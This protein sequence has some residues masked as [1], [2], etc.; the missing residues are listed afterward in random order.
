M[1]KT[2]LQYTGRLKVRYMVQKH[3]L[4]KYHEDAHY[5]SALFQYQKEMAI[6]Y[7]SHATFVSLDDKHNVP[8]G[9]Q[10]YPVASVERGKKVLV[11]VDRAFEVG[12]HDFTHC[13]LTPSVTLVI[14]ILDSIEGYFYSGRLYVGVKDSIFQPSS[15][16]RHATEL[17]SLLTA[18][19][20]TN[21]LLMLYTDSG[22][23]LMSMAQSLQRKIGH[24]STHWLRRGH[25]MPY[26]PSGQFARNVARTLVCTEHGKSLML[27]ASWKP[28]WKNQWDLELEVGGIWCTLVAWT[29]RTVFLL[30]SISRGQASTRFQLHICTTELVMYYTNSDSVFLFWVLCS[31]Y[32]SSDDLLPTSETVGMYPLCSICKL[33]PT[34]PG[35]LKCKRKLVTYLAIFPAGILFGPLCTTVSVVVF[36]HCEL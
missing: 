25:R 17:N 28:V 14:N 3:Q 30:I 15:P 10:G 22:L 12:D 20:D 6:K 36:F 5:A 7:R 34:K 13:S 18:W 11:W 16:H 21:P 2:A 26:S 4:R 24:L 8:V 23:L 1:A 9:K 27:Y 19:S 32:G 33:D 31:W 29:S 35:I